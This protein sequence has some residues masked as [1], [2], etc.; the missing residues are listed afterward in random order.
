[1]L[2]VRRAFAVLH[3]NLGTYLTLNAV[4][5]GTLALALL[6]GVLSPSVADGGLTAMSAFASVSPIGV[7]AFSSGGDSDIIRL[8][9]LILFSSVVFGGL[10]M[11]ILPS[12]LIPFSGILV[13]VLFAALLGLSYAPIDDWRILAAHAPTLLLELQGYILLLVGTASLGRY[14]LTP[15]RF[16]FDTRREGYRRGLVEIG[17]LSSL[18]IIALILGA[19]YEA[20]ELVVLLG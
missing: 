1:M 17:W 9:T 2:P 16:G 12:M 13:H 6:I 19:V 7:D 10:V 20:V 18:A 8:S 5:Y 3:A 14:A 15:R 11:A 4:I